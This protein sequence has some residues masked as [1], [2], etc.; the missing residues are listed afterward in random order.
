MKSRFE[1]VV[2]T[3]KKREQS[4]PPVGKVHVPLIPRPLALPR[5]TVDHR[6]AV[7]SSIEDVVESGWIGF[8]AKHGDKKGGFV[9][10]QRKM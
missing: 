3:W 4:L 5:H 1:G 2:L 10:V 6:S 9:Y 7:D 8:V